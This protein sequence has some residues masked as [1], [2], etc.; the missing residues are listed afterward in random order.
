MSRVVKYLLVVAVAFTTFSCERRP[1]IE[2][3]DSKYRIEFEFNQK[4]L[5]DTIKK[6]PDLMNVFFYHSSTK[7]FE[8]SHFVESYGGEINIKPSTYNIVPYNFNTE[9]TI[10]RNHNSYEDIEATTNEISQ[11]ILERVKYAL[12]TRM[13]IW[14]K[15]FQT[16]G[17]TTDR[18]V[19]EPD[20][21]FT[22]VKE[23]VKLEPEKS[24]IIQT[25]TLETESIV[26]RWLVEIE[27]LEGAEHLAEAS[28]IISGAVPNIKLGTREK[29]KE[30]VS[31]LADLKIDA[32]GGKLQGGY[33]TFGMHPLEE[34]DP[35]L[36]SL[37]LT[38][39]QGKQYHFHYKLTNQMLNTKEQKIK[40]KEKIV[41]E[42]P[43]G[44]GFVPSVNQWQ[45]IV[46]D[47]VI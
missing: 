46:T 17:G 40:V 38:D 6:L 1:L 15:G 39:K 47:I 31:L 10:V 30:K 12:Q 36:I 32:Q 18:I 21:L 42:E 8:E 28:M 5:N 45:D 13:N 19:N 43:T 44:G 37:V 3:S 9:S 7:N 23:K 34:N 35:Q 26:E 20:H 4:V 27:G 41:I 25:V 2:L 16:K 14:E 11:Y 24:R 22:T 33:N 29:G